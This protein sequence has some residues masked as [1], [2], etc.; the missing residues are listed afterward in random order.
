M[1]NNAWIMKRWLPGFF[2]D[3][4]G[5]YFFCASGM[6]QVLIE[7]AKY[8]VE[9]NVQY[10]L[11]SYTRYVVD[12]NTLEY[13]PLQKTTALL[14]MELLETDE[15]GYIWYQVS[16]VEPVSK[17]VEFYVAS[18]MGMIETHLLELA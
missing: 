8:I 16:E 3:P 18:S 7:Y 9:D 15:A 14:R 17:L 4:Q 10:I 13:R 6:Y 11:I 1:N 5:G 12:A 2:I